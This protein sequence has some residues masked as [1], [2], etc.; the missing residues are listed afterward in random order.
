MYIVFDLWRIKGQSL[1]HPEIPETF[2]KM[3]LK[4]HERRS[5]DFNDIFRGKNVNSAFS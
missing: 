2:L 1:Q 5:C 4:S 3:S